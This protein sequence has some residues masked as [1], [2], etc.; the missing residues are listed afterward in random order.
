MSPEILGVIGI[1]CV[2]LLIVL[3]IPII[4]SMATVGFI[5]TCIITN[6]DVALGL[7]SI[8]PYEQLA[9]YTVTVIPLFML[10]GIVASRTDISGDLFNAANAWLGRLPGGLAVAA[11]GACAGFAAVCGSSMASSAAMGVVAIPEMDKYNYDQRLSSGAVCAAASLGIM[12][13]PSMGF[14]LYSLIT[15]EPIGLLFMAGILPGIL[16][17]ILMMIVVIIKVIRNPKLAPLT[18]KTTTK[19]KLKSL[20][21]VIPMLL[22]FLIVMG[23]IFMGIF[24]PTEAGGIGAVGAI[25]VSII[26]GR[27][28]FKILL[29]SLQDTLFNVVNLLFLMPG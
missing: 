13:P 29:K 20:I 19:E 7:L 24:T 14:I 9:S 15:E 10:M 23:G 21:G 17:A 6:K 11:I 25:A 3:K 8:I 27:F 28:K 5:G 2:V 22:L 4:I 12:I 18:G 26:Y 16:L 1:I